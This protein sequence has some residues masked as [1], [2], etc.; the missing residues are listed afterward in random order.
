[1]FEQSQFS[2]D[3]NG[4]AFSYGCENGNI[5]LDVISNEILSWL[6]LTFRLWRTD[7]WWRLKLKMFPGNGWSLNNNHHLS[8]SSEIN[9]QEC[10][11]VFFCP[12]YLLVDG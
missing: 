3:N 4:V 9:F 10:P 8:K 7:L 1:M 6:K 2:L 5:V 12:M 11:E